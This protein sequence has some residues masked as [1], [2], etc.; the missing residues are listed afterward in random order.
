M[1]IKFENSGPLIRATLS[2]NYQTIK[3]YAYPICF[4]LEWFLSNNKTADNLINIFNKQIHDIAII[5]KLTL[6]FHEMEGTESLLEISILTF[7]FQS[8][9][10]RGIIFMWTFANP[11]FHRFSTFWDPP[12]SQKKRGLWICLSFC[13]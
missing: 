12:P 11:N 5:G 6:F 10:K 9:M 8:F 1:A 13:L 3:T 7:T 2:L 4:W